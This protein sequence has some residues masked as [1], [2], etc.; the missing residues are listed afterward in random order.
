MKNNFFQIQRN[1][2]ICVHIIMMIIMMVIMMMVMM[3]LKGDG[4]EN[5][6]YNL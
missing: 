5:E 1:M 2:D 6:N 3:M 4:S